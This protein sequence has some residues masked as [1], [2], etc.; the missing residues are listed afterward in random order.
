MV[1]LLA[2]VEPGDG[3]DA[4]ALDHHAEDLD[5]TINGELVHAPHYPTHIAY[6]QA[7]W[8]RLPDLADPSILGYCP[9]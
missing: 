6:C 7:I 3:A 2:P 9:H 4:N 8:V 5:A 1:F